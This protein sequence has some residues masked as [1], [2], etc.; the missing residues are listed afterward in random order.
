MAED[1]KK[2][3]PTAAEIDY[4]KYGSSGLTVKDLDTM[5]GL[6]MGIGVGSWFS[7]ILAGAKLLCLAAYFFLRRKIVEEEILVAKNKQIQDQA[8]QDA[9]QVDTTAPRI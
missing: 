5:K 1:T 9:D 7:A 2:P 4:L 3:E 8:N 6:V